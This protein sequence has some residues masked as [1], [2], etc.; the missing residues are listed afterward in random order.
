MFAPDAFAVLAEVYAESDGAD[1]FV[2]EF[3]AAWTKVME[4]DR[5]DLA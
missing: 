2:D 4:N 1:R 5:F 3:V